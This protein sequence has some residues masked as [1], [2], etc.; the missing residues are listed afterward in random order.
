MSDFTLDDVEEVPLA[1]L[2]DTEI[3]EERRE[4]IAIIMSLHKQLEDDGLREGR[5]PSWRAPD[6]TW[7]K[8]AISK[9]RHSIADRDMLNA[10]LKRR[11]N[12]EWLEMTKAVSLV[13]AE[14]SKIKEA[15][16]TER[17][18]LQLERN[19]NRETLFV[20]AAAKILPLEQRR[21]IW[22][23]AQELFPD[24]PC[25][26]DEVPV[27]EETRIAIR[28]AYLADEGGYKTL[29]RR[30]DLPVNTIRTCLKGLRGNNGAKAKALEDAADAETAGAPSS[31]LSPKPR[32]G[33]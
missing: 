17:V 21:A 11:S 30:F 14:V 28:E 31:A 12:A 15:E 4:L 7:R 27:A 1:H 3:I 23:K 13:E 9:L 19:K 20:I 8:R 10:E 32:L 6:P 24:D 5:D 16:K 2:S 25:W 26:G 29:A 33:D 18:R 22:A